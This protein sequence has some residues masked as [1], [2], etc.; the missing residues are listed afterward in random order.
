MILGALCSHVSRYRTSTQISNSNSVF[1]YGISGSTGK[2]SVKILVLLNNMS[3][4]QL[5]TVLIA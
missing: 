1:Y 2:T 3:L 5:V 4:S